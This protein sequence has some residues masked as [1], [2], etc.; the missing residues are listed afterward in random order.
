[1]LTAFL[2]AECLENRGRY[3]ERIADGIWLICEESTWCVPAHVNFQ[4]SGV[5]LPDV[6]EPVLD[7]F[8][9]ETA[10]ALAW[11]VYLL[12]GALAGCLRC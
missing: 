1:M 4:R 5:G 2:L 10:A 11:T 12:A 3:L 6:R 7:L 8:A 9:A